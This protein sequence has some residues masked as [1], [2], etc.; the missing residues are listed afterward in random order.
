MED[1]EGTSHKPVT[2]GQRPDPSDPRAQPAA[3]RLARPR[4]AVTFPSPGLCV[5][6][7]GW[8]AGCGDIDKGLAATAGCG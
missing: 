4:Y 6:I 7:A 2:L 5:H 3:P 1:R 8:G